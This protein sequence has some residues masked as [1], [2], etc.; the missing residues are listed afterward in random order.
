[1]SETVGLG[2]KTESV[3]QVSSQ[4]HGKDLLAQ[5]DKLRKENKKVLE[6]NKVLKKELEGKKEDSV[7]EQEAVKQSKGKA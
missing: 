7:D 1:M 4:D 6:E 2:A 5:M 3:K